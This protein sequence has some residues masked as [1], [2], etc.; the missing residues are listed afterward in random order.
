[1]LDELLHLLFEFALA[2]ADDWRHH[3]HAVFGSERHNSLHNLLDRL[4]GDC[5]PAIGTVRHPD[6]GEQ[7]AKIIVDFGNRAHCGTR[8]TAG[9][10]LL[11][12]NGGTEP[13]NGVHVR[14][15]HLV[16]ELAGVGGKRLYIAAL[17]L[18]VNGVKG[19]RGLAG[20]AQAGDDSQGVTRDFDVYIL[21]IMLARPAYRN[22]GNRHEKTDVTAVENRC[23]RPLKRPSVMWTG[24]QICWKVRLRNSTH[25]SYLLIEAGVNAGRLSNYVRRGD[26]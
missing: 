6:G 23:N 4:R 10:L 2:A 18:G 26:Q 13:V 16:E 11:D 3:H 22:L 14:T 5:P 9:G 12:R 19:Q 15:F 24:P 1:M 20:S 21:E 7:E 17:T 25:V 8:A